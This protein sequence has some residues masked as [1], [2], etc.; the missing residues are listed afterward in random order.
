VAVRNV[1]ELRGFILDRLT[2]RPEFAEVQTSTIYQRTTKHV[3]EPLGSA[4]V[5]RSMKQNERPSRLG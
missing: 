3:P 4:L 5:G 2:Q 1:H